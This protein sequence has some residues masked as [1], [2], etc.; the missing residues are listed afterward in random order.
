MYRYRTGERLGFYGREPRS[1]GWIWVHAVSLGETRAAAALVEAMRRERPTLRLLLTHGTGTGRDAGSE[2]L[3]D[4]DRQAWL[5]WDT[6]GATRRF[7]RHFRPR[8]GV[9]IE[10]EVWPNLLLQARASGVPMVLASARLSE[11]SRRRGARFDAIMR[12][13]AATVP[14]VLAQTD[15]D[16]ARLRSAG[17]PR[18]EVV[19][20]LKFDI[21][22]DAD[23]LARGRA[24]AALGSRPVVLAA[25]T[26]E[27]EEAMLLKAWM[28]VPAPRPLLVIVPRHPQRFD[29]VHALLGSAG[30]SVA[31]R[32]AWKDNAAPPVEAFSV[33]AWLGD[34][35][36]EMPLYYGLGQVALLGGSFAPFGG[37]NLIE[38]A[39]CGCPVVL[40]PH[41]FNFSDAAEGAIEAGAAFRVADIG[42]GVEKVC[43]LIA[44]PIERGAASKDAVLF[45][46]RHRG[47]AR[48]MAERIIDLLPDTA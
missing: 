14:L 17:A 26:R 11:R 9:L 16:A 13:V 3:R 27:G 38:A 24:W 34:S 22:P 7:L 4:G 20:N 15:G 45:A 43:A 39:A 31:R 32:S 8:V 12:P 28:R 23:L 48:T 10:T 37:Q 5:P 2:L 1:T 30:L 42:L 40:G 18:V 21:T 46:A 19:G 6:P 47:A 35:M 44:A 25:S 36:R 29:D 33:D 41:T